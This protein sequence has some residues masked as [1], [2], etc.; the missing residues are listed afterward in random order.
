MDIATQDPYLRS[1]FKGQPEHVINFFYYLIQDLR[2]IMAKL[3]FRTIDE[4]VGHSEKL[5][6]RDDVNAKAINID[7]SPILTPAHVIR[8]GV[9]T[10][11][12][13]NKTTNFTPV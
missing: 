3:G 11:F 2:Q 9:P 5:K 8:P 13:K 1:K 6:K 10:K 7:L 12:T 4:M